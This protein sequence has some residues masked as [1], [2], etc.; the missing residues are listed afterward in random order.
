MKPT[1]TTIAI[2]TSASLKIRLQASL[3][4]S[5]ISTTIFMIKLSLPHRK[6]ISSKR[7]FDS[8]QYTINCLICQLL[9]I[10]C[11]SQILGTLA[12]NSA[13]SIYFSS[14]RIAAKVTAAPARRSGCEALRFFR[15]GLAHQNGLVRPQQIQARDVLA[16]IL[17]SAHEGGEAHFAEMAAGMLE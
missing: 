1:T 7:F 2:I 17:Q 6:N 11:K 3:M 15:A 13:T 12:A 4:K 5:R 9:D 10:I 8:G 16:S 14:S